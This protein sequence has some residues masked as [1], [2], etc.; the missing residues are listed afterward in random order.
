MVRIYQ[1]NEH[2]ALRMTSKTIPPSEI[3]TPK[4]RRII[5]HMKGALA[6][7]IDGVAIAAPQI[8]EALRIFVVSGAVFA[9]EGDDRVHQDKTFINPKLIKSSSE[10]V[11]IDEGC[12]SVRPKYGEV[13]RSV[14]ATVRAYNE[15]GKIFTLGGSGLL[16][17]IFQHEIDH[18]DGV[19]FVDKARN[20]RDISTQ[21]QHAEH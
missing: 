16:A 21:E 7:E 20:V 11:W 17:Q 19:L 18:L 13:H 15:N 2:E 8:G 12:L 14:K 4:I 6:G 5:E 10:K 1:Q 9:K 3:T